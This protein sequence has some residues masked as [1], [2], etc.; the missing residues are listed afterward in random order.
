MS[1]DSLYARKVIP[2][3]SSFHSRVAVSNW[4]ELPRSSK[5]MILN[6]A[7]RIRA[8]EE[9]R[10]R[11]HTPVLR[12]AVDEGHNTRKDLDPK[13]LDEPRDVLD[14]DAEEDEGD[15]D[16]KKEDTCN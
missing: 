7:S 11:I 13:P 5:P 3:L 6:F 14:E 2:L 8:V 1:K 4:S 9:S 12:R 10:G 16:V 15:D